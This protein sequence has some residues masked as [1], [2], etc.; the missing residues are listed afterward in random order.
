M[1]AVPSALSPDIVGL[2]LGTETFSWSWR[3]AVLYALGIGAQP[4]TELDL[5]YEKRG[6]KVFPTFAVLAGTRM[7][8]RLGAAVAIDLGRT[9]HGEEHL[10]VYRPLPGQG[11]VEISGR[12]VGL[13]DKGKAAVLAIETTGHDENGILFSVLATLFLIGAGGFGGTHGVLPKAVPTPDRPAD[14]AVEQGIPAAQAALYRLSGDRNPMHIDPEFARKAGFAGAF[15]HGLCTFGFAARAA[16]EAVAGSQL[17]ELG[18][19][20]CRFADQVWP[21]DTLRTEVWV[22]GH[23]RNAFC[24]RTTSS[25]GAVVLSHGSGQSSA[26]IPGPVAGG[27][28]SQNMMGETHDNH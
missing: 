14:H 18:A 27:R 28:Q 4:D 1:S 2:D 25:R 9:L 11:S 21:G 17:G 6:P 13:A 26:A 7:M 16:V 22:D 24:F 23:D 10:E 12:I 3:D 5:L 19:F 15:L 20:R 8:D